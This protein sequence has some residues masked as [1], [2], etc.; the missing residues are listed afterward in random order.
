MG[1]KSLI[2][3]T[4][5]LKDHLYI[6]QLEEYKSSRF[7]RW[8]L[9][10][11]FHRNLE[12]KKKLVWTRKAQ[13]LFSTSLLLICTA[14]YLLLTISPRTIL[15]LPL[16]FAS[17]PLFLV[18]SLALLKPYEV[19]NKELIIQSTQSHLTNYPTLTIIG[20]AGSFGK[21]SVKEILK[22]ILSEKYK[23]LTTPKSYNTVFGIAKIV[24]ESLKGDHKIF[25]VELGA[26]Q[27]GEIKTICQMTKPQ[28]GVLT[29]INEQHLERFGSLENTIAAKTELLEALPSNGLAVINK[30]SRFADEIISKIKTKAITYAIERRADIWA[31]EIRVTEKGSQFKFALDKGGGKNITTPLLGRHNI[32]NILAATAVALELGMRL[33]DISKAVK[34]LSPPPHRLEL[35]NPGSGVL[36][37]DDSYSANP[38]GFKAALEVFKNFW[39]R[40]R[41]VVTPGIVELGEKEEKIHKE[42]GKLIGEAC[43][44]VIFVGKNSRT[45]ALKEGL[46]ETKFPEERIAIV[47]DLEEAKRRLKTL[48]QPGDLI[49]FENDLPDQ[50]L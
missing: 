17:S 21:T 32:S 19:I 42:L 23:V 46:E 27:R 31:T 2:N 3:T 34:N 48:S 8:F 40:R 35:I 16:V 29:G 41:I 47:R 10:H 4:F 1:L 7:L 37:I 50:Y 11:P 45:E 9:Q 18:G 13:F 36:I 30:D 15:A 24:F 14:C 12:K 26:Y 49:L 43:D 28:I 25:I 6:L 39:C 38:D 22:H 20:I 33:D 44:T 5:P